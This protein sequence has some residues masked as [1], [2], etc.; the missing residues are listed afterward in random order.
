MLRNHGSSTTQQAKG[1]MRRFAQRY[2]LV[3]LF[4]QSP[5][6]VF[7]GDGAFLGFN[8]QEGLLQLLFAGWFWRPCGLSWHGRL[9]PEFFEEKTS[10]RFERCFW[11]HSCR[12]CFAES[13]SD[14]FPALGT[15]VLS[16]QSSAKLS[17]LLSP[18]QFFG[19]RHDL[20]RFEAE[21]FLKFFE[22]C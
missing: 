4:V 7:R 9:R 2:L 8:Q 13:I 21:L 14:W 3:R 1:S 10:E 20:I 22:R 19:G 16:A 6:P 17:R 15:D 12:V 11:F 18:N 5:M